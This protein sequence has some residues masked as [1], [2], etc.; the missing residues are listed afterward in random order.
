MITQQQIVCFLE[1]LNRYISVGQ[2]MVEVKEE[3]KMFYTKEDFDNLKNDISGILAG[4][5]EDVCSFLE[6]FKDVK[7]CEKYENC[8][9]Y[10]ECDGEIELEKSFLYKLEYLANKHVG[11]GHYGIEETK[12]C[13]IMSLWNIA[14]QDRLIED[15]INNLFIP[16]KTDYIMNKIEKKV[17]VKEFK[18]VNSGEIGKDTIGWVIFYKKDIDDSIVKKWKDITRIGN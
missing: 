4:L 2:D 6:E 10:F 11:R 13:Y 18:Y 15:Y 3:P 5:E 8:N 17:T 12:D 9:G 7:K 16:E 14:Y 1:Q